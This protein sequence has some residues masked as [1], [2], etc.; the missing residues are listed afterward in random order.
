[1][2]R[3]TIVVISTVAVLMSAPTAILAG[4]AFLKLGIN[5]NSDLGG[6]SDRWFA[7]VGSDWG[8]FGSQG[9]IGLEFQGAYHSTSEGAFSVKSVPANVFVNVKWKSEAE[10]V[11]PYVGGGVGLVSTYVKISGFG[12]ST[13]E[14]FKDAG[15]Q[16]MGGVEFNRK[17]AVE[18][19]GQTV[20]E[21]EPDWLWSV[22]FGLRF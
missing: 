20:F 7:S 5:T 19:M 18:F 3:W 2:Q 10:A 22:L 8:A 16:F 12:E 9:F 21:S 1:M 14:W 11:R 13:N 17:W 4:D 15:F 6:F